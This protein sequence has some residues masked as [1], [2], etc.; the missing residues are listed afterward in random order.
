MSKIFELFGFRLDAWGE[1]AELNCAK[2]WC[3]FMNA[4]CDGG[5]NRYLSAIDLRHHPALAAKFPDKRIVQAGVCS[6]RVRENEQPWIVCPRRLLSLR[7]RQ[8]GFDYQQYVKAQLAR[9][10]E[11]SS[12]KS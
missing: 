10:M 3:P 1:E 5:G 6:L 8:L 12:G 11:L 9:H 4:T 2:A 7:E